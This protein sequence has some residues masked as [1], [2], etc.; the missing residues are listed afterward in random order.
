MRSTRVLP[1][2]SLLH[3]A[4]RTIGQSSFQGP[5]AL[6]AYLLAIVA[7]NSA[8]LPA[9]STLTAVVDWTALPPGQTLALPD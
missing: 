4:G 9:N 7:A 6:G 2:E 1:G 3:V 5:G 8:P